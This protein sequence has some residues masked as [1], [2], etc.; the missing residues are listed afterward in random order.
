MT[1]HAMVM[2][3]EEVV[4]MVVLALAPL[5][6]HRLPACRTQTLDRTLLGFFT[7]WAS[8]RLESDMKTSTHPHRTCHPHTLTRGLRTRHPQIMGA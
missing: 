7:R 8:A 2:E 6:R 3:A 5:H 4:V 1:T